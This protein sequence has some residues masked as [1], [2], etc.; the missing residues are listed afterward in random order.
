[1]TDCEAQVGLTRGMLGMRP[2]NGR[3]GRGGGGGQMGIVL[4][5]FRVSH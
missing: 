3:L 4:H 5:L 2:G 1:M